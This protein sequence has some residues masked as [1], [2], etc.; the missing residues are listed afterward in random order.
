[1]QAL[2]PEIIE[3]VSINDPAID[4]ATPVKVISEYVATRDIE[5]IRPHFIPGEEPQIFVLREIPN[6][7]FDSYVGEKYDDG[8]GRRAL[9]AGLVRIKKM[10]QR[11]GSRLADDFEP[12]RP[13]GSDVA[14]DESLSRI[15]GGQI[16]SEIGR[17]AWEHSFLPRWIAGCFQAQDTSLELLDAQR[18][19]HAAANRNTPA[20]SSAAASSTASTGAETAAKQTPAPTE[21]VTD[22]SAGS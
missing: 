2:R 8:T 15:A 13:T 12:V 19:R 20:S 6:D 10:R 18:R 1:M 22:S 14:S 5:I 21:T 9:R 11:D 4:P 16:R 3:V 17:V 7:L